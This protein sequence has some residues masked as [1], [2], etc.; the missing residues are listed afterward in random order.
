MPKRAADRGLDA[1]EH[2]ERGVR[3]GIAPDFAAGDRQPGDEAGLLAHRDHVG[4]RH[5]DVFGG[6]VIAAEP[7]DR[8]AERREHLGRLGAIRVGEHDRLAAAERQPGH[9]VLVAH[10]ARQPQ[11]VGQRVG[12]IGIMPHPRAARGGPEVGRMHRD[13]R[14]QPALRVG[15]EMKRF[16]RV[17]VGVAPGSGH[18]M[19]APVDAGGK[20]EK[21]GRSTGLE[22]ATLGTTNRCSNQLSYDRHDARMGARWPP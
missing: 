14:A 22:P 15:D 9:G 1:E 2:A 11:R 21:M 10:P 5:A 19:Q 16:V 17:E 7:I 4:D 8:A 6:D 13:D 20:T 18:A 12:V 3:A